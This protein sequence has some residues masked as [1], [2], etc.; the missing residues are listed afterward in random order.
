M[1]TNES[2]RESCYYQCVT[3][4]HVIEFIAKIQQRVLLVM[5]TGKGKTL[6]AFQ[7]VWRLWKENAKKAAL[8]PDWRQYLVHQTKQDFAPFGEAIKK[9]ANRQIKKTIKYTKAGLIKLQKALRPII[10]EQ[11]H[12]SQQHH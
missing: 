3:I 5:A 12:E 9:V 4:N 2:C 7:V 10:R 1:Y 11:Q 6:T 8:F